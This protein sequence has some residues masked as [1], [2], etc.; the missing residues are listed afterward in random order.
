[1]IGSHNSFTYLPSTSWLYNKFPKYWR[2]QCDTIS[3]Q[4]EFGIRFFDIRV[5]WNHNKWQVCHGVVNLEVSFKSLEEICKYMEDNAP[6]A[7]YRIV[8]EKGDFADRVIFIEEAVD[9][10]NKFDNLWR[11]D[12]KSYKI[13]NGYICNNDPKL[14]DR[15]YKFA[16]VNTWEAPAHELRG[17]VTWKTFYK[18]N[19]KEEA[20]S[21]NKNLDFFNDNTK[22]KEML[23][24]KD[25]LYFL[26]YCTNQYT[27][28]IYAIYIP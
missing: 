8:L 28:L 13:W 25:E 7:I 19:L 24:S 23:E 16:L 20:K 21:I 2:T 18:D 22:L 27:K 4:Y 3:E 10:C 12:I 1:M 11:I 17:Y 14:F 15:G 9:L 26:D 6:E 5:C